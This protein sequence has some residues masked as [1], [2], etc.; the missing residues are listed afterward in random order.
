MDSPPP[1]TGQPEDPIAEAVNGGGIRTVNP[2]VIGAK[3]SN[4][5]RYDEESGECERIGSAAADCTQLAHQPPAIARPKGGANNVRH[6]LSGSKLPKGCSYIHRRLEAFKKQI[7]AAALEHLGEIGLLT[8]ARIDSAAKW[9]RHA[10]LAARWLRVEFDR[11]SHDQRLRYS[12]EVSRAA[13]E[14][15]KCLA[16]ILPAIKAE[17]ASPFAGLY[18]KPLAHKEPA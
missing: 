15:D 18:D 8:A 10:Q 6:G 11:L 3:P 1:I 4:V 14:R 16:A 5:V 17:E 13:A 9:E 7:E 12:A 2:E